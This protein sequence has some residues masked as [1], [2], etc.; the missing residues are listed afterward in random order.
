MIESNETACDYCAYV[1]EEKLLLEAH[2]YLVEALKG[3]EFA[4][5]KGAGWDYVID[6]KRKR[7]ILDYVEDH[8]DYRDILTVYIKEFSSMGVAVGNLK[9]D[10]RLFRIGRRHMKCKCDTHPSSAE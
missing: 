10:A 1:R 3:F 8:P 9:S 4:K 2:D 7:F 5:P 6:A